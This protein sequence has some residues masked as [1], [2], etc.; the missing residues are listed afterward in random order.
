M[1]VDLIKIR[2]H[3]SID[4]E[5]GRTMVGLA[6]GFSVVGWRCW[7]GIGRER[8]LPQ[9]IPSGGRPFQA[10]IRVR[11]RTRLEYRR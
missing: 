1:F 8:L 11:G 9:S 6:C 2:K 10:D 5:R 3:H 4:P 7:D